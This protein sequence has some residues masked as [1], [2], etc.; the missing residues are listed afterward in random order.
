V[1]EYFVD[2]VARTAPLGHLGRQ[3]EAQRGVAELLQLVSD[4]AERGRATIRRFFRY[5][6]PVEILLEG[7]R[8][9]G[10][11]SPEQSTLAEGYLK[12]SALCS[13]QPRCTV[14]TEVLVSPVLC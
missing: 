5:H 9:A 4:F 3:A 8:N 12:D 11:A 6:Q 14:G 13:A 7:L 2:P 1:P 10:L